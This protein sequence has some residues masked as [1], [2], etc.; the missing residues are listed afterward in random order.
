MCESLSIQIWLINFHL[1]YVERVMFM[2][3]AGMQ[4]GLNVK[5]PLFLSSFNQNWNL[6]TNF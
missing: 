4:V 1:I 2:V 6:L 5:F 3:Y